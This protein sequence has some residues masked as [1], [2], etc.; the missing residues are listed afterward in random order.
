MAALSEYRSMKDT[1]YMTSPQSPI[2][3]AQKK[4]FSGLRYFDEN[5]ALR[6]VVSIERDPAPQT[7]QMATSMGHTAVFI[8]YGSVRFAVDGQA[9]VLQ[10]YQGEGQ[11]ELFLPFMD[12]TTGNETYDAGRYLDVAERL[13]GTVALDFNYAY[14]PYCAYDS[15]KWS[16]PLPPRE[17]CLTIRIEAGEMKFHAD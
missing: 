9:Q 17:N 13:D 1:F 2:S 12:A 8:H 10:L 4:G 3:P 14:N 7:V 6:F 15:T 16:C 11:D 5:P